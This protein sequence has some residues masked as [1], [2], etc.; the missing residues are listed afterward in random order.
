MTSDGTQ[1]VWRGGGVLR[2]RHL[3]KYE[4]ILGDGGR[5]VIRSAE[6]KSLSCLLSLRLYPNAP[7]P[8]KQ[9]KMIPGT[10]LASRNL[11]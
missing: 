10:V 6:R 8:G 9:L 7:V 3:M 2:Q 4:F 11:T 1:R 5:Q